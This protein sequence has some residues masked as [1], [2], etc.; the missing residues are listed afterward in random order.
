MPPRVPTALANAQH[1]TDKLWTRY[2]EV[3][4]FDYPLAREMAQAARELQQLA[5]L[6]YGT[7][8]IRGG[9]SNDRGNFTLPAQE[10]R[11]SQA[12]ARLDWDSI[13]YIQF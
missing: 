13:E 3:V 10:D 2:V 11:I 1:A 12:L 5:H 7:W 9:Q 6:L 8:Q 4:E